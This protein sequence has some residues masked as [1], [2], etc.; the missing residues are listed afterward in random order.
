M[1]I[2]GEDKKTSVEYIVCF[3]DFKNT[4]LIV[5]KYCRCLMILILLFQR[6]D[7]STSSTDGAYALNL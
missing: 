3:L 1:G 2:F 6:D 5:W 4:K 7:G